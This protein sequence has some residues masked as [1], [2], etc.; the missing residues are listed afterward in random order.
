M[1]TPKSLTLVVAL[2]IGCPASVRAGIINVPAE[3]AK[4]QDAIKAA[5][6][7]DTVLIAPGEYREQITLSR[8]TIT[9]GS[10]YLTTGDTSYVAQTIL[11]GGGKSAVL[12]IDSNVGP[13]TTVIGVTIQNAD[14]GIAPVAKFRLLR[15]RIT[16]CSDGVDYEANSGGICRGNVFENNRDDGIDLDDFVDIIIEDNLIRNNNDDGIEIR[17]HKYSGPLLSYVLRGN[18]IYGN[19]EDGIQLIDY[20][21]LSDRVFRIERNL[22][23]DNAMAGLG[24]MSDGNTRE[25]YEGAS[26]PERIYLINNTFV[27]NEYGVTGGDNLIALN[28]LIVN[29]TRTAMKNVDGNSIASYNALWANGRDFDNVNK[30]DANTFIENPRLDGNYRLKAS[31]PCIDRG[32]AT[33]VWNGETVLNLAGESYQGTAPDIG[34][35][36]YESTVAVQHRFVLPEEFALEQN[37]PNPFSG[38]ASASLLSRPTTTIRFQTKTLAQVALEIYDN[39]G[40]KVKTLWRGSKAPGEASI[41]WDGTSDSG[42]PVSA[43]V[44]L[45]KLTVRSSLSGSGTAQ[46]LTRRMTVLR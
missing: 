1:R 31:S 5:A 35:F 39:L 43:G 7:G 12:T 13:E 16:N 33:F 37:Y 30:E 17:L 26:I 22:I 46:V 32:T 8:K 25:N 14:D 19:G 15:C 24:C 34:A 2:A 38:V 6:D 20:P 44:Y 4:I 3:H 27:N 42:M 36:E 9:M 28:N 18:V 11:D 10:W 29:T 40:R 23:Y 21:D 45:Y 41:Q